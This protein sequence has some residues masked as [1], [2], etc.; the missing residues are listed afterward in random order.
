MKRSLLLIV[1]ALWLSAASASEYPLTLTDDLGNTLTL[2][3]E[4]ERIVSM[5]PSHTETLCA[6][7]ACDKLIGVDSYSNYPDEVNDLPE[8][9]SAF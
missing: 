9:G 5:M 1:F 6:L 4:P 2:E 8:L 7:G 3:R